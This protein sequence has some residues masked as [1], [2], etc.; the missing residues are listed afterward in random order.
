MQRRSYLHRAALAGA[1]ALVGGGGRAALASPPPT[2]ASVAVTKTNLAAGWDATAIGIAPDT[3]N[4]KQSVSVDSNGVTTL[5]AGG[6]DLWNSDD[7]GLFVYSKHTGDGSVTAH[8]LSLT[9]GQD[10]GWVKTS[11]GLRESLDSDSRDVRMDASSGNMLLPTAR[12]NAGETPVHPGDSGIAG[13]GYTGPG[14]ETTPNAGRPIGDGVW[15]GLE[16]HGD[17]FSYYWSNDGKIWTKIAGQYLQGLPADLYA[18]IEA[19]AH[20]DDPSDK[21]I[22]PQTSKLDHVSVS[23]QLL[24]PQS[25]TNIGYLGMDKSALVSW[26]PVSIAAGDV[27]Y[28]VY[29]VDPADVNNPKK[30]TATP[31]KE[32]SFLVPNLTNGT[33]Y[34]FGVSAVVDGVESGIQLPEPNAGAQNHILPSVVPGPP[35]LIGFSLVNIGTA[36]PG[37]AT[38]TSGK[39]LA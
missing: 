20:K 29:M 36:S 26:N 27:T 24:A 32:S 34:L 30:L 15:L 3:I 33:P 23:S 12:V 13:V 21:S 6:K 31:V 35:V 17:V 28:N 19:S 9:G 22:T 38:L 18:G 11:V 8:L 37:T 5:V 39:D 2:D 10:G 7:G 25:I 4:E 1:L 16:R 14:N